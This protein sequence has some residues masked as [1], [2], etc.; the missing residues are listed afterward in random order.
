MYTTRIPNNKVE[1][2][3]TFSLSR[4]PRSDFQLITDL[5]EIVSNVV[6]FEEIT[7]VAPAYSESGLVLTITY[8]TYL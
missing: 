5:L 8:T 4:G 2:T 6:L 7:K 3:E 1:K